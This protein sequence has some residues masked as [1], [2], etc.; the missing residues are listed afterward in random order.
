MSDLSE[1]PYLLGTAEIDVTPAVGSKLAGFA[2]RTADSTGVYLP[3]RCIATAITDRAGGRT[4]L[5]IS[6][7]WLGFYD[8][9]P[10]VRGLIHAATG[11]PEGD[12]LLCG[13]HTHCGPP[14]R[15]FVDADCREGI[16][17]AYLEAAFTKVVTV[18][19]AALA[20][21]VPV[22]LSR[23]TG[24]CGFAHSRRRPDG[25]GGVTWAPTLDA[26]HDHTVPL[27]AAHTTDGRLKHVLFGYT[28]HPTA[29][30]AI[31]EFGGD[32]VGFALRELEQQL[33]CTATFLQGCAGDQKP[34]VPN[35]AHDNFPQ[36]ALTEIETMGRQL[37]GAVVR[38]LRH[39]AWRSVEGPLIID[40]RM[41]TL[42]YRLLTRSEYEAWLDS[43]NDFF[44]RWARENLALL[45]A[46][47]RTGSTADF[48]VQTVRFGRSL[49]LVALAGEMSVAYALR[50]VKELG[51]DFAQVWPIGYAN[52]IVGYV[53]SERQL[54]EGGY[55]VFACMQYIMKSGPLVAGTEDRI[56]AAV[57]GL[58]EGK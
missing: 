27:L 23:A 13:T 35:P 56:F 3:L 9:T 42:A 24:W 19:Q 40:R 30:G 52:D 2:A 25:K 14:I 50:A 31:L 16:D 5:L 7:E 41:L 51:R 1:F 22:R 32:Y 39:G 43:D 37:A 48:E 47:V 44:A 54:A 45:D 17:E 53:C 20:D 15:R 28:A 8:N 29:A 49:A 21:R 10:R 4:L 34:F 55:E 12:I 58:L 6:I 36:Y 33:G 18:A 38:E 57:H 26:P 46:G 11:V